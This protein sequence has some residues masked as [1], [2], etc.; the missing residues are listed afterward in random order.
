ME[1]DR[2]LTHRSAGHRTIGR[3][4]ASQTGQRMRGVNYFCRSCCLNWECYQ[5]S[6]AFKL[7]S[8][9]EELRMDNV[10]G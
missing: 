4:E 1:G 5:G 2:F 9:F 7:H 3:V 8:C 6:T 10:N